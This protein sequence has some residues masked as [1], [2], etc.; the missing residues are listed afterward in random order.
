MFTTFD[1]AIAA[2]VGGIG[3]ILV[4]HNV[5]PE[6]ALSPELVASISSVIAGVVAWAVPN[7]SK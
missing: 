6:G 7:K 2:V 1:K 5:I 4:M 3:S